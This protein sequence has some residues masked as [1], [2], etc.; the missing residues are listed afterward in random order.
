MTRGRLHLLIELGNEPVTPGLIVKLNLA[1]ANPGHEFDISAAACAFRLCVGRQLESCPQQRCKLLDLLI[2]TGDLGLEDVGNVISLFVMT[3]IGIGNLFGFHRFLS[4]SSNVWIAY[5]ARAGF[6]FKLGGNWFKWRTFRSRTWNRSRLERPC[7][8]KIHNGYLWQIRNDCRVPSASCIHLRAVAELASCSRWK[9]V[10]HLARLRRERSGLAQLH[11]Q[12]PKPEVSGQAGPPAQLSFLSRR[13]SCGQEKICIFGERNQCI[14]EAIEE[15]AIPNLEQKPCNLTIEATLN[16]D[17]TNKPTKLKCQPN[18]KNVFT[19]NT[20]RT[21]TSASFCILLW[22]LK[23]IFLK[24]E[25][26]RKKNQ[27]SILDESV[28]KIINF[29][30]ISNIFVFL[31]LHVLLCEIL[32]DAFLPSINLTRIAH[33]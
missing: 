17:P 3:D 12:F 14:E 21:W 8:T 18:Q 13:T 28:K 6:R 30:T 29:D 32:H 31:Q 1:K 24:F 4:P 26:R 16:Y 22:N 7:H 11:A 2:L 23:N 10:K 15:S 27:F 9:I 33:I 19:K 25:R 5:C 20:E